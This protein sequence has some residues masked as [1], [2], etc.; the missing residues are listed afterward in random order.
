VVLNRILIYFYSHG[1]TPLTTT[2]YN[3][4]N[5]HSAH[6]HPSIN[7]HFAPK[8]H[9]INLKAPASPQTTRAETFALELIPDFIKNIHEE[10]V[11]RG[12]LTPKL[13][14]LKIT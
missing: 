8:N 9:R 12:Y 14:S 4:S 5:P 10:F 11:W 6:I 7:L 3:F 13:A 1:G 2:E